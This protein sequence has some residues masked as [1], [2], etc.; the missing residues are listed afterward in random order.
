MSD[1][2][3]PQEPAYEQSQRPWSPGE[4]G[5]A[6]APPA[7]SGPGPGG[8]SEPGTPPQSAPS[9]PPPGAPP[10]MP[11]GQGPGAPSAYGSQPGYGRPPAYGPPSGYGPPP[12]YTQAPRRPS[13]LTNLMKAPWLLVAAGL[14][15]AFF[16][17]VIASFTSGVHHHEAGFLGRLRALDF[18]AW[19]NIL[20]A[21]AMVLVVAL[22]LIPSRLAGEERPGRF[23][24]V[25]LQIAAVASSAIVVG[26]LVAL[27]INLTL[28]PSSDLGISQAFTGA[29]S[30]LAAIPIA[31]AAA[32]WAYD[33]RPRPEAS[34]APPGQPGGYGPPPGQPGG[35]GPPP[36]Q[37]GGYGPPPGQ[38]GGYGP[39]PGQ[40]G[41]YGP[42]PGQPGG[43][44]PPPGQPGGYGPPPGQP[45][46]YGPPPGQPG[47]YGPPPQQ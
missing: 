12:G 24:G 28:I 23:G 34:A 47:G 39:P 38:P 21:I 22:V 2:G 37:P 3:S 26:A 36:G 11:P 46:G 13:T 5:Q 33:N 20:G 17:D 19:A 4:Q 14:L 1:T 16:V 41:G 25:L 18:L 43:Y 35:Y 10:G 30:A 9:G 29:L 32:L 45:G 15:I 31:A 6:E 7:Q 8:Y 42:P 27:I 44:G 40:P